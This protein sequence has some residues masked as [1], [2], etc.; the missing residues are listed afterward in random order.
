M[1][2][3]S[4]GFL[5]LGETHTEYPDIAY[6][7]LRHGI[8]SQLIDLNNCCSTQ[9]DD[10]S[11]INVRE[12]RGYHLYPE[13]LSKID[14]LE[15]KLGLVPMTNSFSVIRA[16]IDKADYLRNLALDG[17]ELIPTLW[18]NRGDFITLEEIIVKTGWHD[19]V[20]KPTVSSKSWNTYRVV[21]NGN[22][23]QIAKAD[24][25]MSFHDIKA[26]N[27]FAEL[28]Q[29]HDLCVQ[30]FM[31]EIFTRG[32]LS[33]VFIDN[34]FSHAIRKTVAPDNW[35]AHEF[36]GG[37]NEYYAATANEIK[38]AVQ[39]I[40]TLRQK[41]GDFLYAR[42]DAIPDK[43]RLLLLECETMVPRLFLS[44]GNALEK[45]VQAINKRLS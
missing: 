31:P 34:E 32:E 5:F 16:A 1:N 35:L 42:I 18:L 24:T 44:E 4:I 14:N 40:T 43:Q 38:W 29:R 8:K 13:F 10:Y 12:C 39:I 11:L 22:E 27:A 7:L 6:S 19:F 45:Y 33:F 15:T 23:I 3:K 37:K 17:V 41:Y 36:F 30:K 2:Q 28:I 21:V 25:R 26:N 9:W 20:I